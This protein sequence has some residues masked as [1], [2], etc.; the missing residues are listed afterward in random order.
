MTT[1]VWWPSP[2]SW[3]WYPVEPER[4]PL[5]STKT[6]RRSWTPAR[7]QR[8]DDLIERYR[9]DPAESHSVDIVDIGVGHGE[10]T[11][12]SALHAPSLHH[13]AVELH[14][15]G[16]ARLMDVVEHS[17]LTNIAVFVGDA[18]DLLAVLPHGSVGEIRVLFPDPWPKARHQ[19]RRLLHTDVAMLF[20]R[21]LRAQGVVHL[22][23]DHPGYA[24]HIQQVMQNTRVF[25]G[26]VVD[27]PEWRVD[28]RY[29]SQA[30]AAGRDIVDIRYV[31]DGAGPSE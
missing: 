12:G 20:A 5:R 16:V 15:P 13:V 31:V 27:R 26:G 24:Q 17:G 7:Q 18:R 28:S 3:P 19:A 29:S 22:T 14:V 1:T 10:T 30:A 23:T 6:R 21:V 9:F 2:D 4:Q 8:F 11:I 25:T